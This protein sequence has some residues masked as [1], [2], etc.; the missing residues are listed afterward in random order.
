MSELDD[1]KAIVEA[2]QQYNLTEHTEIHEAID[3]ERIQRIAGDAVVLG[4]LDTVNVRITTVSSALGNEVIARTLGDQVSDGLYAGLSDRFITEWEDLTSQLSDLSIDTANA[5]TK[6]QNDIKAV[7]LKVDVMTIT[8]RNEAQALFT[9]YDDRLEELDQRVA[10]YEIMLQD[11][12]MDSSQITMDN[13]EVTLGAWTILSQAREWDLE[14]IRSMNKYQLDTT[15]DINQAL[16]DIQSQLPNANDIIN[17]ALADLAN[18]PIIKAMDELLAQNV[19]DIDTVHAQLITDVT[20]LQN[21]ILTQAQQT[22][23][24]LLHTSD[25]LRTEMEVETAARI[26]AIEREATIRAAQLEQEA[27][28]RAAEIDEKLQDLNVVIDGDLAAVSQ[29]I[30]ATNNTIAELNQNLDRDVAAINERVDAVNSKADAI[31]TE[32]DQ[33]IL[34]LNSRADG[35]HANVV[36]ETAARIAAIN[37]LNDGLTVEISERKAGDLAS[38][39]AIENYK[40]SNDAAL[41]NVREEI[42]ANVTA[43]EANASKLTALDVRLTTNETTA[44]D[45]KTL[46]ASATQK[47]D[48]ALSE[49]AA[50]ANQ[51][52]TVNAEVAGI[53]SSLLD[54]ADASAVQ[55]LS[56]EVTA[57][58]GRV[59]TNTSDLTALKTTVTGIDG[60]VTG[61]TSAI[62]ELTTQQVVQGDQITQLTS[63]TTALKNSLEAVEDD[64]AT[65]VDSTAFNELSTKVNK[66]ASDITVQ[67]GSITKL[68][69]DLVLT[70][71]AV[72]TKASATALNTLDTKVTQ[73]GNTITSQGGAITQLQNDVSSMD[74][75]L[76]TKA[77]SAALSA[78]DT[79]VTQQGSELTS[80]GTAITKLE[81]DLST[82]N[83]EL[84]TKADSAALNALDSKVTTIDGKVTSQGTSLTSLTNRV[85]KNEGD[86]S[87]KAEA[88][89]LTALTTRVTNAEGVNTSQGTAITTLQNTVNHATTGLATK[90]STSALT[91][92]NSEVTRINGVVTGHTNQLT[93]LT[94]DITTINGTLE[95]KA[96]ATAL[97]D[98]Y[99]KTQADTKATQIA[100]G[101]VSKYDASLK[102]GGE[103]LWSLDS[104]TI[105]KE[106]GNADIEY[107]DRSK[108][109]YKVTLKTFGSSNLNLMRHDS[110]LLSKSLEDV[111]KNSQYTLS[112]EIRASKPGISTIYA[113][114]DGA[115]T[116]TNIGVNTEWQRFEFTPSNK[117]L[118]TSATSTRHLFA[119]GLSTANGWA[120]NDWYEVRHIQMQKGTKATA[121]SKASLALQKALDANATAITNTNTEVTRVDGIVQSQSIKLTELTAS[122]AK[123]TTDIATKAN[124]QAVAD[125]STRV[126]TTENTITVQSQDLVR[127]QNALDVTNAAVSQKADSSA[128]TALTTEVTNINNKVTVNSNAI[129]SLSGRVTTV[130]QGLTTKLNASVINA[131]ST[132]VDMNNA[133][134][135]SITTYNANLV[136]GG[137]NQLINSE[138]ERTSTAVSSRE[139][140][141]YERNAHLKQFYEGNLGKDITVSFEIMVPV[142]GAV[143]VYS[144]SSSAHTFNGNTPWLAANT[145]T[146]VAVTV[147]PTRKSDYATQVSSTLEFLG[148]Y[149]T[150]RIPTVR[151]VQLEAG[152]KATAWSPS[153]RDVQAALDANATAIQ[154][155]NAN[156]TAL[157]GRITANSSALTSLANRVTIAEGAITQKADATTL[158]ALSTRVTN[159]EN[160]LVTQGDSI[161]QIRNNI[162]TLEG[163]VELKADT[164]A[165]NT[166]SNTVTQQ[167]TKIDANSAALTKVQASLSLSSPEVK[168]TGNADG[169][170]NSVVNP[171]SNLEAPTLVAEP[172]S[173]SGS[174]IRYGNNAGNDYHVVNSPSF[175]VI[176]PNKLYRLKYRIR[177]VTG[178]GSIYLHLMPANAAKTHN[179]SSTNALTDILTVASALY[180][181]AGTPA[182]GTW[183]EGEYF[184]K[185]KSAGAS[186][187]T[188]T[189]AN[190]R[191]FPALSAYFRVGGLFNH[192]NAAGEQDVDYII[193]EDYTAMQASN[194]NASATQALTARV[195]TAEGTLTNQSNA[196]TKLQNDLVQTNTTAVN[197]DLLAKFQGQGKLLSTDPTFKRNPS[198]GQVITFGSNTNIASNLTRVDRSADNPTD[199][200]YEM[201]R[202]FIGDPNA[203][204]YGFSPAN[205][206]LAARANAVFLQKMVMKI[207]LGF[208]LNSASN[209]IGTAASG[210]YQQ[211]IGSIVGT[212]RFEVYYRLIVCGAEGPFSTTGYVCL[213]RTASTTVPSSGAPVTMTIAQHALFDVTEAP[214]TVPKALWDQVT[215]N[216][217]AIQSLDNKVTQNGTDIASISTAQTVLSNRIATVEGTLT[218]KAD[219]SAVSQLD[220]RVTVAE[221]SITSNSASI[222]N[223]QGRLTTVEQGLTT[224]LNA[225]ALTALQTTVTQQGNTQTSQGNQI[226]TLNNSLTVTTATANAAL[227]KVSLMTGNNSKIFRSVLT[228]DARVASAVGNIVIQTPITFTARMFTLTGVG[229][230]QREGKTDISFRAG[231]YAH[232]GASLI[233]HSATNLGSMPITFRFGIRNGCV[234]LI[235]TSQDANQWSHIK[236]AL[237]AQIGHVLPPDTWADGWTAAIVL[238]ADLATYGV[239]NVVNTTQVD[240][241]TSIAANASAI[242]NLTNTVTQQGNSITSQSNQITALNN[243]IS[244]INGTLSTKADSSAVTTLASRVTANEGSITSL[245]NQT[246]NLSNRMTT[247]EGNITATSN[248]L[249]TLNNKV[250]DIDGKVTAQGTALTKVESDLSGMVIGGANLWSLQSTGKYSAGVVTAPHASVTVA[251][252][253]VTFTGKGVSDRVGCNVPLTSGQP[254]TVR[255]KPVSGVGD[256]IVHMRALTSTGAQADFQKTATATLKDGY[257]TVVLPSTQFPSTTASVNFGIGGAT[258]GTVVLSEVTIQ[259]GNTATTWTD[260]YRDIPEVDLSSYAKAA[261]LNALDTKVT[262]IDGKVTTHASSITQLQADVSGNSSKL[263][264]QGEVVNGLKASYV[265]KTDVN[266]LVTGYGLYNENGVGA[267][268][269]NADYFYVGRGT[270]A[271]SGKKPFMVLT[272]AQTIGGVTYPA[273]TWIDAALIASATIGTA[274]IANAAITTAKIADLAVTNAKIGS[275]S[276]EKITA[277]TINAARIGAK[278]ITASKLSADVFTTI[279]SDGAKSTI[280]GGTLKIHYP[281]GNLAV[282]IGVS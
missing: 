206:V 224:K 106:Q 193:V 138:A 24:D 100:A 201:N 150:G 26:D 255:F 82:V 110:M 31:K 178:S 16:D 79:K 276:A 175:V 164:A 109:R 243:N 264:V 172:S 21:E 258:T 64:L 8:L 227:P 253:A 247:A 218:N 214:D 170:I 9:Q 18:A 12:T 62:S 268:G 195:T 41:A 240:M 107:I 238:E 129:T 66:N 156:V 140:L 192:P 263:I 58:D 57:L 183:I 54:K 105:A 205:P 73:Q 145:W 74:T 265:V 161:T 4:Q 81:N 235:L 154:S 11:I 136:I 132:T 10:K 225:S 177:R 149:G 22:A 229:Y 96:N 174:V 236:L 232:S 61:N 115:N 278:S 151:K 153:P 85:T 7:D 2:N 230:S 6:L 46:A 118:G 158:N 43:T 111:D 155:T 204:S 228:Y 5:V 233:N 55:L 76:D 131:Y 29:R 160:T 134:A 44:G 272:T 231:G 221:G 203:G 67:A 78:L 213:L 173:Y 168:M 262:V 25:T 163:K 97:N 279:A 42:T 117:P 13:G 166:L 93:Q 56:A 65:K 130:E 242:T 45:A 39:T 28:D 176:D 282:F 40:S 137:V 89:A 208:Y 47:A 119:F 250:T 273:G 248:T 271:T 3:F 19:A 198:V 222:T 186:T 80:Q 90:A 260:S 86:I 275:L 157:D 53:K 215:A 269:V 126:T 52:T 226:T 210:G 169:L 257:Y 171:L 17:Q 181:Y 167:G 142:A 91:A 281:N 49:T 190:P 15:E 184:Y 87:K 69:S 188:G 20:T 121:F 48:T 165:L 266:G 159:T 70:N 102:V 72:A 152:N 147:K 180:A 146:K 187:G 71:Q 189:L 112:F 77:S 99:T 223:L 92:T 51:I 239:T 32:S 60:K 36:A 197:A 133:I 101:E 124:A 277:G 267:F 194:A 199:S 220:S 144:S 202:V 256:G 217:T 185:G 120:I 123:N 114:F 113:Y 50:L 212:G 179:V 196:V 128:L 30:D 37:T 116:I 122:V 182:L 1:L 135:N 75:E 245:S 148:T 207:P 23:A 162:T 33:K 241:N 125:L 211:F 127:L 251:G 274:H 209:A 141:L 104:A 219:A 191:T 103:N 246:T 108:E 143:Q 68:Q 261:A 280:E 27:L 63:D 249:S 94:S 88:T 270:T 237:D 34:N 95:T 244:T 200:P 59:S 234:C 216:A 84:D 139:Y 35:I 14:I 38:I 252:N 259:V 254:V 83:T 98:I